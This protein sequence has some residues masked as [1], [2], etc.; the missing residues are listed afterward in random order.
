[1]NKVLRKIFING[2][3]LYSIRYRSDMTLSKKI[4]FVLL[5]PV[6]ALAKTVR[7][8]GRQLRYQNL[9]QRC[10]TLLLVPLL[11]VSG[12]YWMLGFYNA[13]LFDRGISQ[14]R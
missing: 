6:M 11:I 4:G 1:M 3:N 13:I 14:Q 12:F 9:R 5:L 8:I 7:I 10:I 2:Q